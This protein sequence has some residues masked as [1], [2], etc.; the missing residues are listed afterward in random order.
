MFSLVKPS[1]EM[2][3]ALLRQPRSEGFS[4]RFVGATREMCTPPDGY[5]GDHNRICLGRGERV[6]TAA[7]SALRHWQMFELGWVEVS[8]PDVP[9][10]PGSVVSVVAHCFGLWWLNICRIVYVIDESGRF[11]RFGFA[12]GTT[13]NHVERGEER[14]TIEWHHADDSVWY[15]ICAFSQPAYWMVRLGY[16]LARRLQRK[17]ARDSKNAMLRAVMGSNAIAL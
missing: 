7:C 16:P 12:Y 5:D 17:F 10:Q 14:F 3:E 6:F 15:D 1:D 2:I 9:I 4:Y 8:N 11:H 13:P